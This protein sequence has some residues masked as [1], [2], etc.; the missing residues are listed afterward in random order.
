MPEKH[1]V[2]ETYQ[3]PE[4]YLAREAKY[5]RAR[6]GERHGDRDANQRHHSGLPVRQL[7]DKS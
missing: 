3:F 2:E 1:H 4:E 6:I 5:D 7:A